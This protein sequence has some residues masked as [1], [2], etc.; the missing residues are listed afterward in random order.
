MLTQ[1]FFCVTLVQK[2]GLI[3]QEMEQLKIE[4]P[5]QI[6]RKFKITCAMNSTSMTQVLGDYILAYLS[7]NKEV[8]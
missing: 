7:E 6:K 8:A 4:I 3:M 2:E 5:K 1:V